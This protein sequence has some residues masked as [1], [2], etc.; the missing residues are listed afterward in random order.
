MSNQLIESEPIVPRPVRSAK[1]IAFCII[2][3]ILL[4]ASNIQSDIGLQVDPI[5]WT[6]HDDIAIVLLI[7]GLYFVIQGCYWW[8]KEK[9]RSGWWCLIGFIAPIGYLVLMNLKDKR[10]SKEMP[11]KIEGKSIKF[12]PHCG[13]Q[14]DTLMNYCPNCGMEFT[15]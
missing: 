15:D 2:G 12:C 14:L 6:I 4:I 1:R 10:R 3:I 9:G 13:H 7:I 11:V 8:A 5:Y